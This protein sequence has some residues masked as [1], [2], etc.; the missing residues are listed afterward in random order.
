MVA[1]AGVSSGCRRDSVMR[2]DKNIVC[3]Y[4]MVGGTRPDAVTLIQMLNGLGVTRDT[5]ERTS[6]KCHSVIQSAPLVSWL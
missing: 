3:V 5:P 4:Y 2:S 1:R 6:A